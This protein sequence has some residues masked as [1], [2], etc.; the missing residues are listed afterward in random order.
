MSA[1]KRRASDVES[2]AVESSSS[3]L[4]DD[5]VKKLQEAVVSICNKENPQHEDE[6]NKTV[7]DMLLTF[8][9]TEKP[10]EDTLLSEDHSRFLK[11]GEVDGGDALSLPRCLKDTS[12]KLRVCSD[13]IA[14]GVRAV[15]ATIKDVADEAD[16]CKRDVVSLRR[17]K[18]RHVA[19]VPEGIRKFTSGASS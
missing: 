4:D 8:L 9:K 2:S 14:M 1:R 10:V 3:S 11:E 17:N 13:V 19:S 16:E 18:K 5:L 12:H 6:I 15:G 7:E